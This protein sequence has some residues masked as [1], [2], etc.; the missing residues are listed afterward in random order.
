MKRAVFLDRDGTLIA[1][2][3]HLTNPADVRLLPGAAEA[4]RLL[5]EAGYLCLVVTNQSV[6]GRGLL[7]EAGLARVHQRMNEL[8]AQA[9]AHVDAI[10]HCPH[11]PVREGDRAAV[12]H[13]DR[14]PGPGLLLRAAREWNLDLAQSWMVGDMLSDTGAGRNAGCRGSV[15]VRTGHG[16]QVA[17]PNETVNHVADDVRSAAQW[18]LQQSFVEV[19][20]P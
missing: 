16:A 11:A 18:I 2:V 5:H 6:I 17:L 19:D 7:D 9:D 10:Y 20:Q 3:H 14:K 8:L 15:L 13:P 12:E 4:L 1:Q